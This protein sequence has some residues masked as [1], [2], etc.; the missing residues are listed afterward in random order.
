MSFGIGIILGF[1][2]IIILLK[3]GWWDKMICFLVERKVK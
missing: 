2:I 1:I 3:L